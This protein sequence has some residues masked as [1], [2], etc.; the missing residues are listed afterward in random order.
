MKRAP[1]AHARSPPKEVLS[2]IV[3]HGRTKPGLSYRKLVGPCDN[4]PRNM[5]GVFFYSL[6]SGA[7]PECHLN[8]EYLITSSH[9]K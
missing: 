6:L 9:L 3:A 1:Q 7:L 5:W 8:S 2:A 4:A